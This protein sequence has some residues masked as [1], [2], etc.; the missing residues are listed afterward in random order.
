MAAGCHS[1]VSYKRDHMAL[2]F[3][4]DNLLLMN[5]ANRHEGSVSVS[6]GVLISIALSLL[7]DQK[8][9]ETKDGAFILD[10]RRLK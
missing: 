7:S 9:A 1:R 6:R 2:E 8:M 3:R 4:C 10:N 5:F